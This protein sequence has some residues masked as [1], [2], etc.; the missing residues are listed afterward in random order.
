MD[1]AEREALRPLIQEA[2]AGGYPFVVVT[3]K[4]V[5]LPTA[6]EAALSVEEHLAKCIQQ[7]P[8]PRPKPLKPTGCFR[9]HDAWY[10]PTPDREI[11]LLQLAL[12]MSRGAT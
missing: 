7:G 1:T 11:A 12:A 6:D 4:T 5:R 8:P 2:I 3:D 9:Q 10:V